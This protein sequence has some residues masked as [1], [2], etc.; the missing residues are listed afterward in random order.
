[1]IENS[2]K[3]RRGCSVIII[4]PN[5]GKP[6]HVSSGMFQGKYDIEKIL[7]LPKLS[8]DKKLEKERQSKKKSA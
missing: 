5:D 6:K 1:M 2:C 7:H 4:L 3:H 8:L